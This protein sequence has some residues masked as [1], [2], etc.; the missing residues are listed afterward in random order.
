MQQSARTG[1][2]FLDNVCTY[3]SWLFYTQVLVV[4][5]AAVVHYVAP[6]AI[7]LLKILNNNYFN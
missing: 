2:A 3:L 5:S 1:N 6:Q 7:G 4:S